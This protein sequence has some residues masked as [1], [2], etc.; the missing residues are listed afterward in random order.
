LLR[1]SVQCIAVLIWKDYDNLHLLPVYPIH[2]C[3]NE[4]HASHKKE[5]KKDEQAQW[6][7][8]FPAYLG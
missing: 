2:R 1:A 6:E 5:L 8:A 4:R 3:G 7:K